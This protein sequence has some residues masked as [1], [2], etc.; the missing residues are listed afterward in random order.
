MHSG[1]TKQH[2][3]H[4]QRDDG[5]EEDDEN[6]QNGRDDR[7]KYSRPVKHDAE[8][9]HEQDEADDGPNHVRDCNRRRG[10][11]AVSRGPARLF[12]VPAAHCQNR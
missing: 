4:V 10:Q 5:H 2:D 6:P 9:R 8:E 7:Q 3:N 11:L 12:H 1:N